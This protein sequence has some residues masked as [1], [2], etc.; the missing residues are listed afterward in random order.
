MV[1]PSVGAC[2]LLEFSS[3]NEAV[4]AKTSMPH[5]RIDFAKDPIEVISSSQSSSP[6]SSTASTPTY[7]S[8]DH[9]ARQ[10]WSPCSPTQSDGSCTPGTPNSID[11]HYSSHCPTPSSLSPNAA[12]F[13]PSLVIEQVDNESSDESNTESIASERGDSNSDRGDSDGERE[14]VQSPPVIQAT[15]DKKWVKKEGDAKQKAACPAETTNSGVCDARWNAEHRA[16]FSH[17]ARMSKECEIVHHRVTG[18][19]LCR[20][21]R[22]LCWEVHNKTHLKTFSHIQN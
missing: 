4:V 21:Q 17:F 6:A 12:V 9:R 18:K 15:M 20:Y 13:V 14:E 7:V 2:A 1:Y 22:K 8:L 16:L 19:P 10:N 11:S 3:I 5:L